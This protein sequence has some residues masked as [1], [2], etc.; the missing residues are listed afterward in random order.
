VS[1]IIPTIFIETFFN[2]YLEIILRFLQSRKLLINCLLSLLLLLLLLFLFLLIGVNWSWKDWNFFMKLSRSK[3]HN[4]F[5]AVLSS[6]LLKNKRRDFKGHSPRLWTQLKIQ[7]NSILLS[8]HRSISLQSC[9]WLRNYYFHL[10]KSVK[11]QIRY[12]NSWFLFCSSKYFRLQPSRGKAV[13]L[14]WGMTQ[15]VW[16]YS[17]KRTT[18]GISYLERMYIIQ[19]LSLYTCI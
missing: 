16:E 4:I 8:S 17:F 12:T 15:K 13:G 7:F 10:I 18:T 6:Y 14:N 1:F 9:N 3:F 5:L 11:Y 2:I 19:P